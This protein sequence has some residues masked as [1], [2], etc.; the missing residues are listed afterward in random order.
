MHN[1]HNSCPILT[2]CILWGNSSVE[3]V[4]YSLSSSTVSYSNVQGGTGKSWF[5]NGCIDGDPL[6]SGADNLRLSPGSPCIDAG[7]NGAVPSE[8]TTTI[9]GMPRIVNGTVDMGAFEADSM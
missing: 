3:V 1:L 7:D 8:I 9:D 2:N 5:G 4:D 6:F